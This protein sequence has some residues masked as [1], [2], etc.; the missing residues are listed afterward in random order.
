[1]LSIIIPTLNEEKYL[2]LLLDSI[3]KQ[4]FKDYEIIISDAGSEDKTIEIAKKY[5]CKIVKG[6]LPAKG[7]NAGS[8]IAKG[9]AL[10]FLDAD[11]I[12]PEF[13][14]TKAMGELEN[15]NLGIAGFPVLPSDGKLI[16]VFS[17]LTQKLLPYTA[18]A[19]LSKSSV[20]KTIGG[21]DEKIVFLED[22]SYGKAASRISKYKFVKELPVYTSARR[23]EKDGRFKVYFKYVLAQV[24][25]LFFGSIKSDIFKYKFG[26]YQ[27]KD[28]TKS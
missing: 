1:M 12:L 3:K 25:M 7:R 14:L 22:Y 15:K 21:F 6:G 13:F 4:D 28:K 17:F 24:Y 23:F 11:V 5:N 2:P 20:H 16:D 9:D 10:L 18:V 27:N 26:H 8:K 19:I